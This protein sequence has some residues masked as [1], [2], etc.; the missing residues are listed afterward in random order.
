M[1]RERDRSTSNFQCVPDSGGALRKMQAEP[2]ALEGFAIREL[3]PHSL[4][5]GEI[6]TRRGVEAPT[7]DMTSVPAGP[8]CD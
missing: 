1:V 2:S 6:A 3:A 5:P 8:V 4:P 7:W